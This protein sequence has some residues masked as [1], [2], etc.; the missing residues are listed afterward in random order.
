MILKIILGARGRAPRATWIRQPTPFMSSQYTETTGHFTGNFPSARIPD[1][2]QFWPTQWRHSVLLTLVFTFDKQLS[3]A[4]RK[5]KVHWKVFRKANNQIGFRLE[6]ASF[7]QTYFW[8]A[9]RRNLVQ[10]TSSDM[11]FRERKRE[12]ERQ[13]DTCSR[14]QTRREPPPSTHKK[15]KKMKKRRRRRR[16]KRRRR[17]GKEGRKMTEIADR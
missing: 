9:G 2:T 14:V 10:K 3:G 17:R 15:K 5:R 4:K 13:T 11:L 16:R 7:I 12:R 1:I 8:L 6:N